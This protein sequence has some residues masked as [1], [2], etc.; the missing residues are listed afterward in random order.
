MELI[1]IKDLINEL[2]KRNIDLGKG[3]P[4]NRLRY[5]TKIGWIDHMVR[6]KDQNGIV[7]GHYPLNVLEKIEEIE[8]YKKSGLNNDEIT[9][10]LKTKNN[11]DKNLGNEYVNVLKSKFNLN[12]IILAV[13]IFGFL[14]E[15]RNYNSLNEKLQLNT[16]KNSDQKQIISIAE[17]G[18]NTLPSGKNKVFIN[19][20]NITLKSII[21][22]TFEGRIEPA[23]HYF[24]TEKIIE[25]GFTLETN[26]PVYKDVT[27]NWLVIN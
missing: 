7:T 1:N 13:I 8:N 18:K 20:K 21:L 5:Y 3:N 10:Q 2:K 11:K 17:K 24:V 25:E 6:K 15:L 9:I 19:S 16:I 27:F 14:F 4:Y 26:Y 22:V 23:T 12:Y